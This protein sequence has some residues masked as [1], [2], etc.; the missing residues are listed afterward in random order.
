MAGFTM[1][2][3]LG[4][5]T[6]SMSSPTPSNHVSVAPKLPTSPEALPLTDAAGYRAL[7]GSLHGTPI[8]V[9]VW[10]S[11]C[12]PCNDEAPMLRQ[13]AL[14]QPDIRFM[15]IDIQD[16]KDSAINFIHKYSITYPSLF[17]PPAAIRNSLELVGV[18]DT[19]FY[20]ANGVVQGQV[21]GPLTPS[22]LRGNLAKI[23]S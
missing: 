23:S 6:G 14:D 2:L 12:V 7:I 11:W 18:P 8:V 4:A 16:S 10:A 3:A 13:A 5:C 22:S 9:N 20:D 15:G 17:D 21:I 1:L 19:L